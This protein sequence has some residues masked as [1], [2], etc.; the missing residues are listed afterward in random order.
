[1]I[2]NCYNCH[3]NILEKNLIRGGKILENKMVKLNIL[4][5]ALIL[6]CIAA[7]FIFATDNASAAK[8]IDDLSE[9][10]APNIHADIDPSSVN[11]VSKSSEMYAAS[12]SD[13]SASINLTNEFR[14]AHSTEFPNPGN[15]IYNSNY[16]NWVWASI[17]MT[18]N[19]PDAASITIQDIGSKGFVY[20]N[21]IIGWN[22]Y[23]RFNNGT[24][25]IW[26][27]N[28]NVKT[29][30]GSYYIPNGETYQV[31]I[32]GYI[33]QTGNITNTVKEI[34]QDI[35]S[36]NPYPTVNSTLNVPRAA[37]IRL[38]DEFRS[39][40]SGSAIHNANYLDYVYSVTTT[41]NNGP[42]AANVLYQVSSSGFTP[43]GTYAVST[44]N[45]LTW[46]WN[47]GSYNVGTGQWNINIPSNAT[48]LLAIY[49]RISQYTV[50]KKV[51]EIY[52]DVYNPYC[53]DNTKAKCLIVFDDGNK[54]QYT[55]SFSY[56]QSKGI[57][58]TVY[59]NGYN[60][61]QYGVLTLSDL[62]EMAEAGW[63]IGNHAYDH[64]DLT[65]L[66]DQQILNE[67][68]QQINF[69]LN[70]GFNTSAYH[71]AYPGG[72]SNENIYTIMNQLGML[73]GRT[74]T[75]SLI[76]N[77]N[78]LNLYQIP[79]YTIINTTTL[80]TIK[81]YID[82]A[83]ETDSTVIL[84]FH[85]IANYNPDTYD[86]LTSNFMSVIDYLA[87]TG[88]DCLTIDDLYQQATVAPI[89]IPSR[90]MVYHT[91]NSTS[92]GYAA[93][94]SS[95]NISYSTS[96]ADIEVINAASNYTPQNG[97][98]ITLT[99]TVKNNG[100]GTA[101]SVTIAEWLN[102]NYLTWISDDSTGKYNPNTGIWT[103]GTLNSGETTTL[104]I[105]AR[106]T[107]TSGTTIINTITYNPITTDP[108]NNNNNQ[109]INLTVP[110]STSTADIEVINA[111]SNY[112]PQNG[113]NITLTITVKN[114]GP[115]TAQSVTIA[116][117]LNGNYLTWISDDSTGKYNPNTG[118]WTIGTLNSGETTTLHIIARVTATSGTT[119]INTITYNP[120]TTDPNTTTT[121]KP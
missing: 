24:G 40:L 29:G 81:G 2:I 69:L 121:T 82:D 111:A 28:F 11:T 64:V 36:P 62:H 79:A 118:I 52:Q 86:Y 91:S 45:G 16:C 119:I 71:L 17:N 102:G 50:N 25:W 9:Y 87:S 66:T 74:T 26:D 49:G 73:T 54:A 12:S 15:V 42:D 46:D 55:I 8:P 97:E 22:G 103:I 41:T 48:Y 112:T 92:D 6:T 90:D 70:N 114:N 115:D 7:I 4:K 75:G 20:Y 105:I 99:I 104:H 1:M 88:I 32:L 3:D 89:N 76:D 68:S 23:V 108:N 21:P 30:V 63:I 57:V 95:L 109:T 98:N 58:G 100:P 19:G 65:H 94:T 80:S 85:N 35:N 47:D 53:R 96:T 106:V 72:Y 60:I 13:K 43:N 116:E 61:G 101:Q 10:N 38:K 117:W 5:F 59:V 78:A 83:I 77:Y 113:E 39:T 44:N 34:S 93:A 56:M 37:I 120:I 107:A 67:L 84:L 27:D 110:T 31:A 51:T 18:N 14:D 33:N